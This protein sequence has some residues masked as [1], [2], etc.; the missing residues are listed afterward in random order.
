V[1]HNVARFWVQ[2]PPH[3]QQHIHY[4]IA[5][6]T[7]ENF[8][9][10]EEKQVPF[11]GF[12]EIKENMQA[13]LKKAHSLFASISTSNEQFTHWV[14]RSKADLISLI[15]ET[16]YGLY[17][18]AGVPWYNTAF[19][20]DGIITAMEVL[21]VAPEIA[22]N[23]LMFLANM[24]ATQ[25]IPAKD[26][27]PGKILHEA[28]SGEMANTAEI[29]FKEYYG[30]IDATPLFVML[31]GMYYQHTADLKTIKT[32]WPNIKAALN[33]IDNYGDLD[34]DGFVE[35]KHKAE[36]GLTNQGWKDSHD[37]VMYKNG[38]L[39]EP[40]IALC[41][42]QGYA[43][44]AKN[45]ASMLAHALNETTLAETLAR[46]AKELK[47]KFNEVFWDE[48]SNC[49][50]LALDGNKKP[51]TVV[52]S[53]PGHCLFCGIVDE[54]KA[55]NLVHSL[56]SAQMFSGWGIR[57]LSEGEKRYNPMSYHN[58]SIWPH[59]NAIIASGFARY[60]FQK[61]ASKIL[62]A[63]FDASLF[64]ELQRLPELYCGFPR[65]T[66]EGPTSYPV[67]C[68]PQAW[69]VGAVFMLL[70]ACLQVQINA[71]TKTIVFDKPHLP[72]YLDRI[73]INHLR[74]GDATCDIELYRHEYD[75]GFNVI[76]KPADWNLLIVK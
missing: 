50:A 37:S 51:C 69:S 30:T 64:I 66:G 22:K 54:D 72:P 12:A 43:Y 27:E 7:E 25:M 29:P 3:H 26:A 15:T 10:T 61:E 71:V 14:H 23:A 6:K 42:V 2:L 1:E 38:E 65:R 57:T 60:G 52:S 75:V 18:Y 53:N 59:D 44:G 31:A 41:E 11:S 40:P 16:P 49:Y 34:G 36:N 76:R 63:L 19:G 35:Y 67:A 32:L 33:W 13:E 48:D 55:A 56:T 45:F 8:F 73:S 9:S 70:Q 68:S 58:G 5:F 20:R 74:L 4:F 17:P 28:R 39:C 24:Q 46:E 62:S 47:R 21:W